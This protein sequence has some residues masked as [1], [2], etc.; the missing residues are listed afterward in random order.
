M[1]V[2]DKGVGVILLAAGSS[3]RFGQDKLSA[4]FRG[5]PLWEWSAK[6]AEEA[7]FQT[8][9]VVTAPN[10][11]V[12]DRA[13][14]RRTENIQARTGMGSSIAAGVMAAAHCSRLVVILADMPLVPSAH[15]E[16]LASGAGT[17]FTRYGEQAHGCPAAFPRS[18]FDRLKGLQGD[19]GARKLDIPDPQIIEP[20]ES[21]WLID[22]DTQADLE[23]LS[24]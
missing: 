13:S 22:I 8:K 7:G 6:A 16:M 11:A 5:R 23:R 10:S 24:R 15:L 17:I 2:L 12:G 4:P 21:D 19:A 18:Q 3:R 20:A 9:I 14:W 1:P